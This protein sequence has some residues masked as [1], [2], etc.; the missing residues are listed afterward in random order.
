MEKRNLSSNGKSNSHL[1]K[2]SHMEDN[3]GLLCI[4][5]EQ[6]LGNHTRILR[7]NSRQLELECIAIGR[8]EIL[9][10]IIFKMKWI[11][12]SHWLYN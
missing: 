12:I 1:L 4:D 10:L 6:N 3:I 8:T 9:S 2:D 7:K 11:S 5:R